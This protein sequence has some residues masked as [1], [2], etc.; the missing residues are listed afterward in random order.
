M[1]FSLDINIPSACVASSPS[2]PYLDYAG[3]CDVSMKPHQDFHE[4][5]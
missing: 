2:Q 4:T 1:I 3:K 5:S